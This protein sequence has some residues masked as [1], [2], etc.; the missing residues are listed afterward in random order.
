VLFLIG[1]YVYISR[2]DDDPPVKEK[3]SRGD[4]SESYRE[5]NDWD[6]CGWEGGRNSINGSAAHDQVRST[7]EE[8][9]KNLKSR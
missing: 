3:G 8:N 2:N 5:N 1:E 4:R 7:I 6:V 9:V